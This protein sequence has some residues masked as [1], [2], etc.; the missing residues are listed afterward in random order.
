[1]MM[2]VKKRMPQIHTCPLKRLAVATYRCSQHIDVL[3]FI[4]GRIIEGFRKWLSQK[5]H[6][7]TTSC[8]LD[9][10]WMTFSYS[11]ALLLP[12]EDN[13]GQCYRSVHLAALQPLLQ[14]SGLVLLYHAVLRI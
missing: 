6:L 10:G 9:C 13:A 8:L 3:K 14:R 12:E 11:S 4:I 5:Q 1:M 7:V 2:K